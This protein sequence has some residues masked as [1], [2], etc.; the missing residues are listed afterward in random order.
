VVLSETGAD[1]P[2]ATPTPDVPQALGTYTVQVATPDGS[3]FDA[4]LGSVR[5]AAGV[6]SVTVSSTAIGGT[7]V[8]R[9]TY[10]GDINGLAAALRSAGWQVNQG[11]SALGISR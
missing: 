11:S 2:D 9:V 6:R 10:L 7:S 3:S 8:L 4:A 5:G 1:T